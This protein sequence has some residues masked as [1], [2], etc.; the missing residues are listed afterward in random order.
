MPDEPAP[1]R[2]AVFDSKPYS[3][4]IFLERNKS[5]YNFAFYEHRLDHDTV[6]SAAGFDVVCPFVNDVLDAPVV[7]KLAGC[8]VGLIAMRCAGYNNVDLAACHEAGISVVRVPAYSPHSVAEHSVALMMTLNRKIH[9]AYN[10]V[11]EGNFSLTGLVGFEMRSKTV[12]VVG[13]GR[14]GCCAVD[15]LLGFGCRV[16]AFDPN[17]REDLLRRGVQYMALDDLLSQSD[18]VSLYVPLMPQTHHIIG[19]RAISRMKPGAMLINTS[20]GGLVDTQALVDALKS[21]QIGSA[22]LDVYEEEGDY[23]FE[24]YSNALITDD[25]LARL[26]TFNNVIVTSHQ[27]FLTHEA[28]TNI[29]DTTL[30]NV[31][32]YECGRR[33]KDLTNGVCVKCSA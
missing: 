2:I 29:A 27:A 18:V 4:A 22:G 7:S 8:N 15:I 19:A 16:L 32:E 17:P 12:G 31:R 9:R 21:G 3:K 14:I 1:L 28:L 20:R 30:E 25:T 33:G 26:L 6:G 23:F 24:D 13:T 5:R 11:R 10:R